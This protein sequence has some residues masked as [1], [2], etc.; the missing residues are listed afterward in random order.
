MIIGVIAAAW[1]LMLLLVL[2]LCKASASADSPMSLL[3]GDARRAR[4]SPT[5]R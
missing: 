2:A 1:M 3:Q 5:R 4:N